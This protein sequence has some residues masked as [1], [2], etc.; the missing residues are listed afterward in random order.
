MVKSDAKKPTA[1]LKIEQVLIDD[2]TPDFLGSGSALWHWTHTI[3]SMRRAASVR[4]GRVRL[5]SQ[6]GFLGD[7]LLVR[8]PVLALIV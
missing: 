1:T 8:L 4:G 5:D 3:V 2:L 7:D 6:T